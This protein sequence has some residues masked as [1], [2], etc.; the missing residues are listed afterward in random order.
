MFEQ[1]MVGVQCH[2]SELIG[3]EEE[4][5]IVQ[6]RKSLPLLTSRCELTTNII[7]QE[8]LAEWTSTIDVFFNTR[9]VLKIFSL[10]TINF[11]TC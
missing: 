11:L 4:E 10:M 3:R 2:P 9:I 7:P 6:A 5:E 8:P 1:L